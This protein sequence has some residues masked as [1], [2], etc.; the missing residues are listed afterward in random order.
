[1]HKMSQEA[2]RITTEINGKYHEP[3]ELRKLLEQLWG[4]DI[5]ESVGMFPPFGTDCGKN[6]WIGKR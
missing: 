2:L 4:H 1:M 5:P 6:T 3:V